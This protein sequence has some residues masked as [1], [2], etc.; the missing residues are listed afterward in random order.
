VKQ[1]IN[2]FLI[3][4]LAFFSLRMPLLKKGAGGR[5]LIKKPP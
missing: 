1:K 5:P 3:N 4:R 2:L